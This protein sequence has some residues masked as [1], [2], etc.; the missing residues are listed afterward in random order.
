M[1]DMMD[2]QPAHDFLISIGTSEMKI[3]IMIR[4]NPD[5]EYWQEIYELWGDV[6]GNVQSEVQ[7][8]VRTLNGIKVR[9]P[10]AG[11]PPEYWSSE[12]AFGRYDIKRMAEE[13]AV[14]AE[15]QCVF[16]ELDKDRRGYLDTD[17]LRQAVHRLYDST[18][19]DDE[20]AQVMKDYGDE[21]QRMTLA[22]LNNYLETC[23]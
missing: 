19:D 6:G 4:S 15:R 9:T 10:W 7:N 1:S 22:G 8:G 16:D 11:T 23:Y 12:D 18:T 14:A 20:I 13:A 17:G 3:P 5:V 2:A 21:S